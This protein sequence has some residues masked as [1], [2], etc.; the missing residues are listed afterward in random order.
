MIAVRIDKE[1]GA[2]CSR[3]LVW[4]GYE[5]RLRDLHHGVRFALS[6]STQAETKNTKYK[7]SFLIEISCEEKLER[8]I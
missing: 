3:C 7:K 8:I 5:T 2:N 1:N 4:I 6:Y